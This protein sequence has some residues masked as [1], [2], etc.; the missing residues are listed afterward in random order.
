MRENADENNSEY[1]HFSRSVQG[2]PLKTL[3]SWR[4]T[5]FKNNFNE[6]NYFYFSEFILVTQLNQ[7]NVN[8]QTFSSLLLKAL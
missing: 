2:N 1:G 5:I 4:C 6:R 8:K 3:N 7:P